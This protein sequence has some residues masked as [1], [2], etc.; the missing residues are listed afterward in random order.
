MLK[1]NIFLKTVRIYKRYKSVFNIILDLFKNYKISSF[2][3]STNDYEVVGKGSYSVVLSPPITNVL[4]TQWYLNYNDPLNND[5]SKV[6]KTNDFEDFDTEFYILTEY[7]M[8]IEKYENFTVK[9]KGASRF[10]LDEIQNKYILELLDVKRCG[11]KLIEMQQIIFENGGIQI[12]KY[13]ELF[14]FSESLKLILNF[15][16]GLKLLNNYN[17][18]HRDVKPTNVLY[19]EKK[20]LLIDFGLSCHVNDVYNWVKSD[21]ILSN[22]YTFS[23]PEFFIY[24]LF[25][26]NNVICH[27]DI[28]SFLKTMEE[29]G[30]S[31]R[32][33]V[34]T[35][36][37]KHWFQYNKGIHDVTKYYNGIRE[38]CQSIKENKNIYDYFSNDLAKKTDVYSSSYI[39][40]TMITKTFFKSRSEEILFEQLY[41][42]SSIFDPLKRCSIQDLIDKIEEY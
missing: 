32:K 9:I 42:M 16:K 20:L 12:N 28:D 21:F 34:S 29:Y 4:P 7:V 37:E 30:S 14:T 8:K 25:K 1:L 27:S 11:G 5:V 36:Y 22:K 10:F 35:Y 23:P 24:Y 13:C 2:M 31:V 3:S 38:I 40:K 6:Y 33:D 18:I 26:K 19:K 17:I 39:I 41:E 15:Y